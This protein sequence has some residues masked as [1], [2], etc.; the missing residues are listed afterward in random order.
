[1][2][3]LNLHHVFK[4]R[5]IERPYSFL[6]KIGI[7]PH[8]ATKI[9][10]NS[11]HVMRLSHIELICKALYCEPNDLLAFKQESSNSLPATHPLLNL[12]PTNEDTNWQEQLKT[13]PIAKLNKISKM[14][15]QPN[16]QE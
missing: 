8:T 14:L 6:V 10:N 5:Q 16:D 12:L 1:M 9:L 2:L 15:N 7:A 13:M 4:I 11:M 3:Y